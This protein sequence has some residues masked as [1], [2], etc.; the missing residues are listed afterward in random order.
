MLDLDA[1]ALS[2][3]LGCVDPAVLH[4]RL[5][6]SRIPP[7]ATL[8]VLGDEMF[9]PSAQ[10]R[11]LLGSAFGFE[12]QQLRVR[13]GR[14]LEMIDAQEGDTL[15]HLAMRVNGADDME[16]ANVV[17][18]LLGHGAS[19]EVNNAA[20]QVPSQIDPPVFRHALFRL[21]PLWRQTRD[22]VR[23]Q[24]ATADA[25]RQAAVQHEARMARRNRRRAELDAEAAEAAR[26]ANADADE[27]Q[28]RIAR[29][30]ALH[31]AVDKLVKREARDA[32]RDHGSRELWQ[33]ATKWIRRLTGDG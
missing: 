5:T 28:A 1:P 19:F 13:I 14:W 17:V 15:L 25:A 16:K 12:K 18:E 22:K 4:K 2:E 20:H 24:E 9:S 26:I 6:I 10:S 8:Y 21:L 32:R 31:Q 27:E 11:E 30:A 7:Q 3:I 33:D 29:H 23:A